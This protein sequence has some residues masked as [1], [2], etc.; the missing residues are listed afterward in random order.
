MV[1]DA[2]FGYQAVNVEGQERDP[3]SLLHWTRQWLAVRRRF[4]GLFGRG[5]LRF[6]TPRNRKV[7]VYLRQFENI[8]VLCVANL[9][10]TLQPVELDLSGFD[11]HVPVELMGATA[12]P[13]IGPAPYLLT[14]APYGFHAFELAG[15]ERLPDWCVPEPDPLPE[16]Q[17]LVLRDVLA[18]ELGHA[19][20]QTLA[21]ALVPDWWQRRPRA[22]PRPEADVALARLWPLQADADAVMVEI[23]S[24]G[25]SPPQALLPLTIVWDDGAHLPSHDPLALA[26]VRRGART[27]RLTEA[28]AQRDLYQHWHHAWQQQQ[29]WAA[30]PHEVHAVREEGIGFPAPLVYRT[31]H[32]TASRARESIWITDAYFVAPRPISEGLA[33]AARQGVDVRILVPAHNNWPIVGSVSRGGYRFLLEHGVRIFE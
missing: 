29:V 13:S 26:R 24:S 21:D 19:H 20:A 15:R 8:T 23:V 16:L 6:L 30:G 3:H 10:R 12:L 17:T 18:H 1:D 28:T 11:T 14:L 27:G 32:L 31:L 5:E 25:S 22:L 4:G 2:V 7:L 9:S 33:A